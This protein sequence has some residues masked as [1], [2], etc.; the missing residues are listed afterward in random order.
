M[1]TQKPAK[2]LRTRTLAL[3]EVPGQ[4]HGISD[5]GK[6]A[7]GHRPQQIEADRKTGRS[8]QRTTPVAASMGL[9]RINA[10]MNN[11]QKHG[12]GPKKAGRHRA[13]L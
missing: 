2:T 5:T 8:T 12:L 13:W 6:N 9:P 3:D 4:F 11:S 7:A 10:C 1:G